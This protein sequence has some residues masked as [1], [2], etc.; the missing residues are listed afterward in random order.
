MDVVRV[1]LEQE[2]S[3]AKPLSVQNEEGFSAMGN[4]TENAGMIGRPPSIVTLSKL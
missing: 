2:S 3:Y 4:G 1:A